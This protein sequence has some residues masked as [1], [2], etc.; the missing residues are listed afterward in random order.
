MKTTISYFLTAL[1]LVFTACSKSNDNEPEEVGDGGYVSGTYWPYAIGNQWNLVNTDDTEDT[2]QYLIHKSLTHEGKTY[3]QFKPLGI[4]ADVELNDGFRE[5]NG[6]FISLHG[7]TSQMGIN[8]S[9]GTATYINTNLKVGEIWKEEVSLQ[10]SGHASGT[11]THFN[12]GRILEKAANATING[13]TYKD[14]LKS[15]LKKTLH[16]SITGHT[17][18]IVY[19]TWLAKGIGIIYE[20]TTYNDSDSESYGLVSYTVK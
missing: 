3:F 12:E 13:K 11:I 7:A 2:Y 16:N 19:E 8:T 15:E 6:V 17:Q 10:I 1:L 18:K 5:E 20:K 14:V 9:A 4:D